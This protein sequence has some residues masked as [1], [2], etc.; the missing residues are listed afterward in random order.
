MDPLVYGEY[1]RI[2]K[3]NVGSRLPTFTDFESNQVK[4]SFDFIGVNYYLTVQI[5]DDSDKLKMEVRNF[6]AD[7]AIEFAG[8]SARIFLAQQ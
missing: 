8:M 1:P 5:K 7:M 2:M 6:D 4:G 3:K